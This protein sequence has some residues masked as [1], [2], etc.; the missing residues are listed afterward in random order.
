MNIV[1]QNDLKRNTVLSTLSLFFQ[2][3]YSAFLGLIA[4]LVLTILV[5]P[6]IFGIYITVLSIMSVFNYFSDIGLAASL[7]QKKDITE[8]DVKT[9]FTVQ[10]ILVI[11]LIIIGFILTSRIQSFYRFPQQG[12]DLFWALLVAFFISSLKTIPSIFLERKIQFQKIVFVQI[13]ENTLFYLAVI[14]FAVMGS[15]LQSFTVAVLVRS[16]S[17]L[18][19]MYFLSFWIPKIGISFSSLKQLLSFG[20]PFQ[21][22]SFLALIKDDLITLFLGKVVGFEGLGYIGW[23]K[24]WAESP[25]RI[26]MDN[27]SRVL[28]PIISRLQHDK[29]KVTTIIEKILYYQTILLAPTILGMMIVMPQIVEIIPKYNKWLPALPLFYLFAFSAFFSSY[30]SPFTNLFNALGKVSISFYFM[31]FWTVATWLL[32]PFLTKTIGLYGFP[33]TQV[34]LS[35]FFAVVVYRAKKIISFR[36]FSPIIKPIISALIMGAASLLLSFFLPYS[37]ITIGIL[38]VFGCITYIAILYFLFKI[39]VINEIKMIFNYDA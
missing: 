39:N 3:S 32:T 38:G 8:E 9:T 11:S 10:Q 31:V 14:I 17:G 4:N 33:L 20:L 13:V 2:S 30:S 23:A 36:F 27:I 37:L 25:I 19:T 7:V 34:F 5:S 26:I 35:L 21:A 24:K 12:V 1:R 29:N 18:I 22:S 15:G 28:F 6:A 16:F